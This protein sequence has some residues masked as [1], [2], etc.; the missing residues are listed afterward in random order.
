METILIKSGND[1]SIYSEISK[2]LEKAKDITGSTP[3]DVTIQLP[4]GEF[5]FEEPIRIGNDFG[6]NTGNKL[7]IKGE[8]NKTTFTGG[9]VIK[10]F[11]EAND[12]LLK[13]EINDIDGIRQIYVNGERRQRASTLINNQFSWHIGWYTPGY[14]PF[15]DGSFSA[16]VDGL[17]GLKKD[18]K[19]GVIV[20]K[21]TVPTDIYDIERVE[22]VLFMDWCTERTK[23]KAVHSLDEV[24]LIE[25]DETDGKLLV[26]VDWPPK[27]QKQQFY[28]E[29]SLTFLKEKGQWYYDFN[30]KALYYKPMDG[31]DANNL[32][33]VI[34]YKTENFFVIE[35]DSNKRVEGINIEDINFKHTNWL[36][37]DKVGFFDAPQAGA[38]QYD[39][40][41]EDGNDIRIS[42]CPPASIMVNWA[43]GVNII[44]CTFELLGGG[45]IDYSIGCV[46]CCITDN[47]ITTISGIGIGVGTINREP[48]DEEI[49]NDIYIENN[50][51]EKVG[52]DYPSSVGIFIKFGFDITVEHN[53]VRY[54]PYTG[55][56]I[57]WHTSD[58][59]KSH[60]LR[61]FKVRK[62]EVHDCT[63][64]V[65]D[66][67]G[68]YTLSRQDGTVIEENYVYNINPQKWF[69][70]FGEHPIGCVAIYLDNFSAYIEVR[71]N[72][73]EN[74]CNPL[75]TGNTN[76]KNY[77]ENWKTDNNEIKRKAGLKK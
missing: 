72:V 1:N 20:E 15:I 45:A 51:V 47:T 70:I 62:N 50:L 74:S 32:S 54:C 2:A 58:G 25:L 29:N 52:L 19:Y 28:L 38:Y 40:K 3:C 64:Y 43:K 14:I 26:E 67:G 16:T 39:S 10:N 7:I 75:Y 36:F 61:S 44:G 66:G 71:N 18:V 42:K 41:D 13:A 8:K 57:G 23:I 48:M 37:P 9:K 60:A 22:F 34:P 49:C 63:L 17:K 4:M 59:Y 73:V 46:S 65:G 76:R 69:F 53:L 21:G 33:V 27:R 35:G 31:E 24:D 55:I 12:G 6:I 30:E 68:I 11:T 5:Y 56:S 77:I